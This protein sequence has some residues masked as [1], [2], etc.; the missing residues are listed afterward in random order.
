MANWRDTILKNFKPKISRLTLVADPDGLLIEEG[1]LSAIKERGF[2]LIPFDD[3]IAFRYAYESQYR[4]QWD[5]G[6]HTDLVVVLRS[7]EQQLN[8][9]PFDLLKAGRQLSFA[10]HQLFPKL[11]Y[12][13]IAGLDRTYLDAV[14]ES[15]Q[16]HD[17]DQLTERE[18][19][20]FV[21]MHC[22]GIVP[23]LVKTPVDLLKLLL[24][25]HSRKVFLPE[26]LSDHLLNSLQEDKAF[27]KWPLEDVFSSREAF[28]RFLQEEWKLYLQ[29]IN[30]KKQK[31][32]VPFE[33]QD[34]WAYIDTF[35]LDGSL[36]PE[37]VEDSTALPA[38]VQAGVLHDPKSDAIRRFHGLRSKFEADI[39]DNDASHR[40]WQQAA[41]QWAELVV[42]RWEWDEALD[43]ADRAGWSA[44]QTKVENAFDQWM[45]SRYGTLHN[46]PYQQQPVMVH[47][48]SRFMAL[49]RT[50][51]KLSKIAL[52][53]LDG[54]AVDQWL[55]LKKSL[56]GND[57]SWR[58]QESTAFAWVPTLTSVTRQ[59]IFAGEPPLYFPE[60]IETTSKE[61]SHWL[62]FWEDQG[63]QRTQV[64]LVTSLDGPQDPKLDT[65][66]GNAR[67]SVLGIVWNKVDDIMHGM[68][69]QTA[70]MH[71]Q[72]KLWASQGHL[73]ELLL[74]LEEEGFAVYLTAD[75]GNVAAIGIGNPKEGVL[76]ET[77]GKRVRVYDRPAFLEEV[78]EKFP[79]SLRWPNYGLPPARH[80]LL[81]GDLKAFT[82]LGDEVV[83]HGGI[84]LEEV[85]VPFVAISREGT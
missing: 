34:I 50:K 48:I 47:Q 67:L 7:A 61:K 49:E 56:E 70:G 55:L 26:F 39:P 51:K 33:H 4:S 73:Q 19:K 68:Q 83:S 41:Q 13:V 22:F 27:S 75:H 8:S 66:L 18:T 58:F 30:A 57:H 79:E 80:V 43:E 71:N 28:L 42:L 84:A 25:L 46:L 77:K 53:V 37:E 60:S 2:D 54:L 85:M 45:V 24:S 15:Y 62:R 10:L 5:K 32:R 59:S 76:A 65:A 14:D 35:F 6:Q 81:A 12:P 17:G 69:M 74:R 78:A 52:L 40:D 11:N 44:L 82:N 16:R 31:S 29:C 23:K 63:V 72:V 9:L 64:D 20:E 38:W 1:M 36:T 21:L 3:S